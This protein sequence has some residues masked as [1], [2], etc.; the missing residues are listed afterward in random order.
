[1]VKRVVGLP[2]DTV[3]IDKKGQVWI[4]NKKLS[5]R[6]IKDPKNSEEFY[7]ISERSLG[8]SY[9]EHLFF[10]E[11]TQN[12]KYRIIQ[13]L[14]VYARLA[15]EV[16]KVPENFF[17]V[18]G[19]NRDNFKDSRYWGHLPLNNIIGRVFDFRLNC[20]ESGISTV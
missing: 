20:K 5:R 3:F 1:M 19:D 18:L 4:N 16:Y 6:L 9:E 15:S 7:F 11:E 14:S 2:E 17:F 12:H 10:I 8:G 13:K